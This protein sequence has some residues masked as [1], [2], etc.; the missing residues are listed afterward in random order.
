MKTA[1]FLRINVGASECPLSELLPV[2]L[3]LA[4]RVP[5]LGRKSLEGAIVLVSVSVALYDSVGLWLT[6]ETRFFVSGL[7][8][9]CLLLGGQIGIDIG[10]KYTLRHYGIIKSLFVDSADAQ[11]LDSFVAR[12]MGIRKQLTFA[13]PI[14]IIGT[15]VFLLV[16]RGRGFSYLVAIPSCLL[17][18]LVAGNGLYF[19]GVAPGMIRAVSKATLRLDYLNP[20]DTRGVESLSRLFSRFALM[21]SLCC[22]GSM[23]FMFGTDL[24]NLDRRS[25]LWTAFS[26]V[27]LGWLFII[28][29]F[30]IPQLQLRTIVR[31]SAAEHERE[32]SEKIR[33]AVKITSLSMCSL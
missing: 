22:I 7:A 25:V 10:R 12:A 31:N 5:W 11:A 8:A 26:L 4:A 30:L 18:F 24:L 23:L 17:V 32:I 28:R 19:I 15:I 16:F 33:L 2:G 14:S 6:G 27:A 3:L 13:I 29:L 9:L 20:G 1:R 21:S